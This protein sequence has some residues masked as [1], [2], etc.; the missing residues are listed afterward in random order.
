MPDLLDQ[1]YEEFPE[2]YNSNG[3]RFGS[4]PIVKLYAPERRK[5]AKAGGKDVSGYT[6]TQPRTPFMRR[7]VHYNYPDGLI[8]PLVYGLK[9]LMEVKNG[10]VVWVVDNPSKFV[11]RNLKSIAGSYALALDMGKWDPQ[12]ISKNPAS[13]EF[14]VNEFRRALAEERLKASH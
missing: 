2:A 5:V 8:I 11:K 1:I 3:Y 4:K 7:P 14:A 10:R 12:K 6:T 9:G 13:H